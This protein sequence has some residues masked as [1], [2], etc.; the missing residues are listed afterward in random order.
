MD[1]AELKR[2]IWVM[3]STKLD[4]LLAPLAIA[5]ARQ[6]DLKAQDALDHYIMDHGGRFFA[7]QITAFM[8]QEI[9]AARE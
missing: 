8:N 5:F 2:T 9:Q 3:T 6:V 4:F 7:P 1:L